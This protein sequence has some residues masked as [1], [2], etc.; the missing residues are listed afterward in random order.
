MYANY[1]FIQHVTEVNL[2]LSVNL[3]VPKSE[4][5][6]HKSLS[7]SPSLMPYSKCYTIACIR[8]AQK[9]QCVLNGASMQALSNVLWKNSLLKARIFDCKKREVG[10]PI[11]V[12][13]PGILN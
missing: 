13:S 5:K 7:P 9:F 3:Q 1:H 11:T 10:P 2:G 8:F 12:R 6:I 4:I